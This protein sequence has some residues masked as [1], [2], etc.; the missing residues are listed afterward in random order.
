MPA[1]FGCTTSAS[2]YRSYHRDPHQNQRIL[3]WYKGGSGWRTCQNSSPT[4]PSALPWMDNEN[5]CDSSRFQTLCPSSWIWKA[6]LARHPTRCV[7]R[8]TSGDIR[9][10]QSPHRYH[11][12]IIQAVW[13]ILFTDSFAGLSLG[14][15]PIIFRLR[16]RNP[17]FWSP[18]PFGKHPP[19]RA[20][21]VCAITCLRFCVPSS[22]NTLVDSSNF[23][24]IWSM[25]F[26]PGLLSVAHTLSLSDY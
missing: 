20:S 15:C 14:N 23:K 17:S 18:F 2:N 13:T 19:L 1:G 25:K 3:Y 22:R 12:V 16:Q 24:A 10:D 8:N 11:E 5:I 4:K 7:I 26:F 6:S 21:V 9:P